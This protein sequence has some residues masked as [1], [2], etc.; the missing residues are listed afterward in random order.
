VT[1]AA[2]SAEE[3]LGNAPLAEQCVERE[4]Q[5]R[6]LAQREC[7]RRGVQFVQRQGRE[8]P[9]QALMHVAV[10]PCAR[11]RRLRLLF[12]QAGALAHAVVTNE[13]GIACNDEVVLARLRMAELTTTK[14]DIQLRHC[15]SLSTRAGV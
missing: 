8:V 15:S 11:L 9:R 1:I 12:E 7:A 6:L 5:V 13:R 4:L 10:I 2:L 3:V 14:C